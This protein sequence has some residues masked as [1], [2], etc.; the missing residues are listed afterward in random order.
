MFI[1]LAIVS[2]RECPNCPSQNC[3]CG[4]VVKVYTIPYT[5]KKMFNASVKCFVIPVK[6]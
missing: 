3:H 6:T 4:T 2:I 5:Y 1:L